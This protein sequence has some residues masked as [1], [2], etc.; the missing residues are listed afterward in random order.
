MNS[1][2]FHPLPLL[3][4]ILLALPSY[5]F[6]NCLDP[7]GDGY[8]TR[9]GKPC[10]AR[11]LRHST[12]TNLEQLAI[13][14]ENVT[15]ITDNSALIN[16]EF[17]K[18]SRLNIKFGETEKLGRS[19]PYSGFVKKSAYQQ[20]LNGL[21]PD[22]VYFYQ[23]TGRLN[24]E[25]IESPINQF[26]TKSTTSNTTTTTSK[27][28]KNSIPKLVCPSSK[29][30]DP[31]LLVEWSDES[32]A[33]LRNYDIFIDGVDTGPS[34]P[35]VT[36]TQINVSPF[37][38]RTS[39][40][41]DLELRYFDNG[42]TK[43][44]NTAGTCTIS[45][46]FSDDVSERDKFWSEKGYTVAWSD[47]P[48]AQDYGKTASEYF[49]KSSNFAN[50]QPIGQSYGEPH[51]ISFEE[52][53]GKPVMKSFLKA[54]DLI[55]LYVKAAQLGQSNTSKDAVFS[56]R[57]FIPAGYGQITSNGKSGVYIG[58]GHHWGSAPGVTTFPSGAR[59]RT[60]GWS[61][62]APLGRSNTHTIYYYPSLPS[63]TTGY[64]IT[65][66]S[67][68]FPLFGEWMLME[69]EVISNSPASSSNG[70]INLYRNGT[71]IASETNVRLRT[72]DNVYPKG[73]G[74]FIRHNEYAPQDEITYFY[75]WKMYTRR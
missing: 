54:G 12:P 68:E 42:D 33:T 19:G 29:I 65:K 37:I 63:S 74:I 72:K 55:G 15:E 56:Q 9:N 11:R 32:P 49:S 4:A 20:K 61:V 3:L 67:K 46:E 71:L 41:F 2:Y 75:D 22:T 10:R 34:V 48:T 38:L 44:I 36:S 59:H 21:K 64:G 18:Y 7:D 57:V 8:G 47:T 35:N 28:S 58:H 73:Y 1:A 30:D 51:Q 60:D 6:A 53:D 66:A 16:V 24:Q 70:R 25:T 14:S 5:S 26:R 13:V 69:L 17:N 62:R 39:N 52:F 43:Q 50:G 45:Y 23:V 31:N 27:P 40:S